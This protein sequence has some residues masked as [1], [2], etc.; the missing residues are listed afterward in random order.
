MKDSV[1]PKDPAGAAPNTQYGWAWLQSRL[2]RASV[3]EASQDLGEWLD[4][5]LLELE[6]D[7]S[8]MITNSSRQM[9]AGELV[10]TRR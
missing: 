9:I 8:V 4:E 10:K 2:E 7:Y 3:A 1:H 6:S 5:R